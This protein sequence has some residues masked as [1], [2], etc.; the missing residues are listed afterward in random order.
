MI[1]LPL[2]I[3]LGTF[4]IQP[5][6]SLVSSGFLG[7]EARL[8]QQ[9][10]P[11]TSRLNDEPSQEERDILNNNAADVQIEFTGNKSY[12]DYLLV[13]AMSYFN[14]RNPDEPYF[15]NRIEADLQGIRFF[16]GD[17]GH[18]QAELG[19]LKV[20]LTGEQVKIIIPVN[21][22]PRFRIRKLEVKGAKLFSAEKILEL[23]GMRSGEIA[24]ATA[25]R[26]GLYKRV[27][28]AYSEYGYA[29]AAAEFIPSFMSDGPDA[30]EG[31]VDVMIEVD[32]G[33][34]FFINSI[35]F[36]ENVQDLEPWLLSQLLIKPG[37][38]YN[39]RL[40]R[41]SLEKL[42][43]NSWFEEITEHDVFTRTNDRNQQI[44]L[45]ILVREKSETE[46]LY[47]LP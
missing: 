38:V 3:M 19:K 34:Q 17:Q 7:Q 40:V 11:N 5:T 6:S 24:M 9:K 12:P 16:L 36:S 8:D 22:G 43:A 35:R 42:N 45:D 28:E 47:Q 1:K 30:V 2:L 23:C 4:S 26:D 10:R 46:L 25:I 15:W 33:K 44:E 41:L 32:E 21:E 20:E 29:Q 27:R 14:Q 31:I 39:K 18:L 37:Q 13:Q